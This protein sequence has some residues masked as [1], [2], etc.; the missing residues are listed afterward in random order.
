MWPCAE[1]PERA[2]MMK[3]MQAIAIEQ[4][5]WLSMANAPTCFGMSDKVGGYVWHTH[6]QIMFYE[7][8]LSE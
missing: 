8:T 2:E 1:G 7:L 4:L 6:N 5:P 3:R